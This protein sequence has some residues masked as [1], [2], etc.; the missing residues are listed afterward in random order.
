MK[1][2]KL[3][4]KTHSITSPVTRVEHHFQRCLAPGIGRCFHLLISKSNL[5][6]KPYSIVKE[7]YPAPLAT[8]FHIAARKR[9]PSL[10]F[11][12]KSGWHCGHAQKPFS[13]S[14]CRR[15]SFSALRSAM[16][17]HMLIMLS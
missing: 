12:Q 1:P 4:N 3:Q 7:E 9:S 8:T 2:D 16:N 5:N 10:S 6:R 15:L 11:F 14:C 13:G 17:L